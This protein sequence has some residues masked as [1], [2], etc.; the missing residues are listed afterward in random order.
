M[1][2]PWWH[3]Q[4]VTP[5]DRLL[6]NMTM[7]A[8]ACHSEYSMANILAR[9]I[10]ASRSLAVE[11]DEDL[12]HQ[13][14]TP[15]SS[16]IL[17]LLKLRNIYTDITW[18]QFVPQAETEESSWKGAA[19]AMLGAVY[20]FSVPRM[21]ADSDP[22]IAAARFRRR[23]FAEIVGDS[24]QNTKVLEERRTTGHRFE[25]VRKV[26]VSGQA[27]SIICALLLVSSFSLLAVSWATH[28]TKRDLNT[29]QDPSTVL[30]ISVWGSDNAAVLHKFAKLDLTTREMLKEELEDRIFLPR[31]GRL[32]EIEADIR[33]GHESTYLL[34][35]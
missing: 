24:L 19:A 16:T 31:N 3:P 33:I 14:R 35:G 26:L 25:F 21:M 4:F 11:F 12:F 22:H 28:G 20:D 23:F 7:L 27:A 29:Y 34:N 2:T 5:T 18:S 6:E 13:M 8:Y 17:N 9:A 10:S 1:S 32:D 15:V 30:G